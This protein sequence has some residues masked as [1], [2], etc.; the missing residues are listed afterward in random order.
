[1]ED[2]SLDNSNLLPSRLVD[3]FTNNET[4]T[5][6]GRFPIPLGYHRT[7]EGWLELRKE[8]TTGHDENIITQQTTQNTASALS[9]PAV[10]FFCGSPDK[11]EAARQK[12]IALK[13]KLTEIEAEMKRQEADVVLQDSKNNAD[14][15]STSQAGIN[16]PSIGHRLS[17]DGTSH[18][19]PS[20]TKKGETPDTGV[21]DAVPSSAG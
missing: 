13:I 1:M 8:P 10:K 17:E 2:N 14:D 7:N 21:R 4:N 18:E 3:R 12:M 11:V 16:T 19:K 6:K 20:S 15:T 9:Q 5:H